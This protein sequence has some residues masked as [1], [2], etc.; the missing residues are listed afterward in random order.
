MKAANELGIYDMSGNMW[1]WCWDLYSISGT[2]GRRL[3][4]GG[5]HFGVD[6][7]TVSVR[8]YDFYSDYRNGYIGFRLACRSGR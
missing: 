7:A 4:G 3:R 6:L 2:A 8:V 1:E 5:W